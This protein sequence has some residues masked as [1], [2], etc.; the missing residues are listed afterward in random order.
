V[1]KNLREL[2]ILDP[3]CGCCFTEGLADGGTLAM[4]LRET[5][6]L[7]HLK[8]WPAMLMRLAKITEYLPA[9]LES[10]T[11]L[12][13]EYQSS[14]H[15]AYYLLPIVARIRRLKSR[16]PNLRTI[17][18]QQLG[19]TTCIRCR[20]DIDTHG[21]KLSLSTIKKLVVGTKYHLG[22]ELVFQVPGLEVEPV[23]RRGRLRRLKHQDY[24]VQYRLQ[25][26]KMKE[27][28]AHTKVAG[29]NEWEAIEW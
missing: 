8:I 14:V 5:T 2:D 17:C 6:S 21:T 20:T 23:E 1:Y 18:I 12:M 28:R 9:S 10:L 4:A 16:V 25:K 11:L 29:R 13:M 22:A 19:S 7:Q 3:H 26:E 24:F 27:L 15:G